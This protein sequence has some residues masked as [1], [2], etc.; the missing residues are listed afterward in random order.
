MNRQI[1][2]EVHRYR[3][4]SLRQ[5]LWAYCG[6]GG[7]P[8][9]AGVVWWRL[10]LRS[11]RR[12]C[13]SCRRSCRALRRSC[14]RS[15]RTWCP[16]TRPDGG[17]D[18]SGGISGT[19]IGGG[20]GAAIGGGAGGAGGGGGGVWLHAATSAKADAIISGLANLINAVSFR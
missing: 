19:A 9:E 12:S 2:T 20:A 4:L 18:A 13:R 3:L 5:P 8:V 6:G 1:S 7:A 14:R 11:C 16:V 15:F 17:A 10:A